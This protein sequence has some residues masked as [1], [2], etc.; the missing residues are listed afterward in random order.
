M[1]RAA[2]R[3]LEIQM[4]MLS[5]GGIKL[6][7]VWNTFYFSGQY[8]SN[9]EGEEQNLARAA[10]IAKETRTGQR[11]VCFILDGTVW[12]AKIVVSE[13]LMIKVSNVYMGFETLTPSRIQTSQRRWEIGRWGL[14]GKCPSSISLEYFEL[15]SFPC[16]LNKNKN[17]TCIFSL[18]LA[19][20]F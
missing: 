9:I 1:Y 17:K 14:C 7:C 18:A 15:S 5:C 10:I 11:L 4:K 2:R 3:E 20:L 13:I 19:F 6:W 12:G 8:T 16:P